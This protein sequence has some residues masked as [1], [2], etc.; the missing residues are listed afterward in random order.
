MPLNTVQY[1][2]PLPDMSWVWEIRLTK[3]YW[4]D[5][6]LVSQTNKKNKFLFCFKQHHPHVRHYIFSHT[7]QLFYNIE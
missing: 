4:L 2:I 1:I 5:M 3:P 6:E 7:P